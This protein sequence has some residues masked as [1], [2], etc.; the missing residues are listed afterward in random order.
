MATTSISDSRTQTR[1]RTERLTT[2]QAL[3]RYLTAQRTVIYHVME[4]L[5]NPAR[6]R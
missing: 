5:R 6:R 4:S 3:V 1:T 2:A